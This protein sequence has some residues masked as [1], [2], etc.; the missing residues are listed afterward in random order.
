MRQGDGVKQRDGIRRNERSR[1]W[2]WKGTRRWGVGKREEEVGEDFRRTCR[3]LSKGIQEAGTL[4]CWGRVGATVK[5]GKVQEYG[6]VSRREREPPS[7]GWE[8]KNV[9][10]DEEGRT[11]G[12]EV[13]CTGYL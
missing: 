10:Q 3:T 6:K 13:R 11:G 8:S 1:G 12:R 4:G 9:L 5:A 7:T 2:G